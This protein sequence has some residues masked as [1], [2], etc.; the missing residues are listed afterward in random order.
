MST[1]NVLLDSSL[2]RSVC[3]TEQDNLTLMREIGMVDK[4]KKSAMLD[5]GGWGLVDSGKKS[6]MLDGDVMSD[7]QIWEAVKS[8]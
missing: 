2:S 7:A 3:L 5:L 6:A 4:V 8:R 1:N